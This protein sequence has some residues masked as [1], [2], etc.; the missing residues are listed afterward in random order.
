[1]PER[2]S[3]DWNSPLLPAITERLLRNGDSAIV[4]LSHLLVVV[5][6]KQAGRRLLEALAL[7]LSQKDRGVFPPQIITPDRLLGDAIKADNLA[8]EES[9]AAAWFSALSTIDFTH[10]SALFPTTPT[11]STGW[12]LGTAKRLMQLRSELGEE[13][14]DFAL[15]ADGAAEAGHEPERWRQLARLEGLA[16]DELKRRNLID[17]KQ[18]RRQ[19]AHAYEAPAHIKGIILAATPDPQ[20]LPLKAIER[21]ALTIPV[22]IWTYGPSELFD[23]WGRPITSTWQNRPLDFEAWD[24]HIQTL[25]DPS[26]VADIVAQQISHAPPES[27]LLGLAD[28]ELNPIVADALLAKGILTYDPEGR[29]LQEGG[30]GRLTELL[31]DLCH[32]DSTATIRSLL[33]HPDIAHWLGCHKTQSEILR[34]FDRLFEKHLAADLESLVYFS[35]GDNDYYA[36]LHSALKAL[37]GMARNLAASNSFTEALAESLQHIYANRDI[38]SRDTADIPWK[39]RA[40]AVQGILTAHRET[41]Q[42]FANLPRDYSREAF[43]SSLKTTKVYPDRPRDA[44]DLLGWL[45]LLWNDAPH[46]IL[47]GLNEGKV[48]ES[49]IGDAFLPETLREAL[50]LRTNAMRFAR[51]AYLLEALCRRRAN[52]TSRIDLLVPQTATDTTPLRPSRLLFLGASDTLLPRTRLLFQEIEQSQSHSAY[53]L[54]WKLSPPKD[55]ELPKSL[56]VSALKSYLECPFRFFLKSILKMRTVDVKSRELTPAGFGTLF[57][58]VLA[59]LKGQT[60]DSTTTEASLSK[61]LHQTAGDIVRRRYG[62]K[63]SFALRLQQEALMAR[64]SAFCQR[65]IEDVKANGSIHI[66]DTEAPFEHQLDGFTIKGTI[67]RIDQRGDR[68]ELIDYKTADTPKTP[69]QAHLSTVPKK[70]LLAHLPEDVIFEHNGKSYYWTDLQLPLYALSKRE[71]GQER[72]TAAYINLAKTLNKSGIARWDDLT[73]SHLASAEACAKAVIRQI[74]AGVFWPPN[75]NIRAEYDDFA[76][77]FPDGIEKSVDVEAFKNYPFNHNVDK[78]E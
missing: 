34:K 37:Q 25:A 8:S 23:D 73:D 19:A 20:P 16:V 67:D 39:D 38:E 70:G 66:L 15:A 69:Q 40:E 36:T 52:N 32:N 47:A 61:I 12:K 77:L 33:Q 3:L 46:L 5:P 24:C 30:V 59:E 62:R 60:I 57:H 13:G 1:M 31:C 78:T 42:Q 21:A 72:P 45:E 58:D 14:L 65:Q 64:I 22:E 54:A 11:V 27:A 43:R 48:P 53:N 55:L 50:G 26:A 68:I 9:S 51:D 56:S 7:S 41:E 28:P 35:G 2:V 10:F 17:P 44:H 6:T 74:K 76:A 49:V 18:A 4:D 71:S 63:L 75:P 29:A